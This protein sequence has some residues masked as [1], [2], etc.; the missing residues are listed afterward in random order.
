MLAVVVAVLSLQ[1]L[2]ARAGWRPDL[3]SER[4]NTLSTESRRLI[5]SIPSGRSVRIEAFVSPEV[6]RDYVEAKQNL[7]N[8]LREYDAIGGAKV[9][10]NLVE[11]ERYSEEAQRAEEVYGITPA[12]VRIISDER[13]GLDEIFLG[14]A[15]TSGPEQ[16]VIPFF[17]RGLPVEYE[18]TR[19]IRT[20]TGTDRRKVGILA[21][22]AGLLSDFDFRSMSQGN[23]WQVV[24]EL[25]KQYEVVSVSADEAV[26]D[27]VDVLLVPQ[28][29][30]LTDPQI[31]HLVDHVRNG[32]PTLLFM[33]PLPS[34]DRSPQMSLA[35][36]MPKES[37]GGPFGGGPPPEQKGDL[38]PLLAML[39]IDWPRTEIVWNAF[40]PHPK[41]DYL[42]PEC[43][44][45]SPASGTRRA[46]NP[47]DAVTSG[48]QE[49]ILLF[50]GH[51]RPLTGATTEFT[52]L[53]RTNDEGGIVRFEELLAPGLFGATIRPEQ[54]VHVAN[55]EPYTVA[56]RITAEAKDGEGD[57]EGSGGSID[58]IV[59][60]D[61]DAVSDTF[62]G[63]RQTG[64]EDF[65]FD[66]VTF[67]LNCVDSLAGDESFLA[68]RKQRRQHRTLALLEEYD[69]E[70]EADRQKRE[71][72]AEDEAEEQLAAA[73]ERMDEKI[74]RI[75]SDDELDERTKQIMLA[76]ARENEQRRLDVAE[77]NIEDQ[78]QRAIAE[79]LTAKQRKIRAVHGRVRLLAATVPALPALL[80]GI[81]VALIRNR[82]E[83]RGAVP[84]RL[85]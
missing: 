17:D 27:D 24:T 4:L 25:R 54:A 15:F 21:T 28:P 35:P 56:A 40:N 19:S 3:T 37:P 33:D 1:V 38:S 34:F 20:V 13:Y 69:R 75:E 83:N 64:S 11:T 60:M 62:F 52:P 81:V 68:L 47:D 12:P 2:V 66:N 79:S 65:N 39:G 10:V 76:Q 41:F 51:V 30:S 59:V 6:P 42:P 9:E 55:D 85:A 71:S 46:F 26:P 48:L 63:L 32:G 7:V 58:A 22:D 73:R 72:A 78:K 57:E 70:Y 14:V 8:L 5:R 23:E 77:S 31:G 50:G 53:L 74:E 80:L 36:T 29:S 84:S 82:R 18:L 16:V 49:M 61:L 44:F 45:I 43:V 67:V